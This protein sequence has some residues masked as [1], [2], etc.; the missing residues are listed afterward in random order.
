[1]TKRFEFSLPENESEGSMETGKGKVS[2]EYL[3]HSDKTKYL[4]EVWR[5]KQAEKDRALKRG[6]AEEIEKIRKEWQDFLTELGV[7][8]PDPKIR[9]LEE[10]LKEETLRETV[11]FNLKPDRRAPDLE[12]VP[13]GEETAESVD[14]FLQEESEREN[15]RLHGGRRGRT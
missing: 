15:W 6:D 14:K 5:R 9:D 4:I 3:P 13:A 12:V 8:S 7:P 2:P 10:G 1:M 11:R